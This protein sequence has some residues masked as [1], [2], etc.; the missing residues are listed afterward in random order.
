MPG[1]II[2][3]LIGVYEAIFEILHHDVLKILFSVGNEV[4]V[5]L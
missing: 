5:E 1:F 4:R 2:M 3:L